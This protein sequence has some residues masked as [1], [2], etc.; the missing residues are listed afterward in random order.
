V[1]VTLE[2]LGDEQGNRNWSLLRGT[3]RIGRAPD[4][5]LVIP[6]PSVSGYHLVIVNEHDSVQVRDLGSTN[7]TFVN[8]RRIDG[9]RQLKDSDLLRIGLATR[10]R[11]R[12]SPDTEPTEVPDGWLVHENTGRSFP[13]AGTVV[14]EQLLANLSDTELT[15]LGDTPEDALA[16]ALP[17]KI[18]LAE[19]V[20]HIDGPEGA[21]VSE[22]G[23][24]FQVGPHRLLAVGADDVGTTTV[25][26]PEARWTLRVDI[27]GRA[28]AQAEVIDPE[29]RVQGTIRA[30]NR[31]AVLHQL[32]RQL[33]SDEAAK[34][35]EADRGWLPDEDLMQGVWGRHWR[36]K[37]P[38]SFQ[39]L[40][41][42]VRKDLARLGLAGAMIEK[43]SGHTR[44]RPGTVLV[45]S[46]E[47]R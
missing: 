3:T 36:N 42:R 32:V 47:Q 1:R 19:G 46:Q 10:A 15:E 39:V 21:L 41:H 7:G 6:E 31:V 8:E 34:A 25:T 45:A 38:A 17:H 22:L 14:L 12:L 9:T 26:S 24:S 18:R 23:V 43:R 28:G 40:V 37:G 35:P 5:D 27:A 29:G 20:V 2:L 4:N 30:A 16:G 33:Q 11:A 13:I 44:L